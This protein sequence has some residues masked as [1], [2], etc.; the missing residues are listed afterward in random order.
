[1]DSVTGATKRMGSTDGSHRRVT[2]DLTKSVVR[3]PR[4]R[5]TEEQQGTSTREIPCVSPVSTLHQDVTD[6]RC[7][8]FEQ[9]FV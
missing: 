9:S 5:L 3:D 7:K 8:R 1:M 4:T 6:E 2:T